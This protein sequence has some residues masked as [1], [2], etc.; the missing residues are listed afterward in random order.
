[1]AIMLRIKEKSSKSGRRKRRSLA[2]LDSMTAMTMQKINAFAK[3]IESPNIMADKLKDWAIPQGKNRLEPR[4]IK[5]S[6][7]LA[8]AHSISASRFPEYSIIIAS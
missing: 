6:N 7:L 8:D 4:V 3:K 5:I 1:M 2:M